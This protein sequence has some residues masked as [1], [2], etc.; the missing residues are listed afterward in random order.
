[1][2][3]RWGTRLNAAEYYANNFHIFVDECNI[4]NSFEVDGVLVKRAKV[5]N[6]GGRKVSELLVN[7][8]CNNQVLRSL[9]KS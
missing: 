2:F 8:H 4:V 9:S 7:I 5:T 1:M 3:T 6:F